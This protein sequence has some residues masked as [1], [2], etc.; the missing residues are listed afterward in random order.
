MKYFSIQILRAVS[1]LACLLA[2]SSCMEDFKKEAPGQAE[3]GIFAGGSQTRT[4]MLPNGLS[5]E[6]VP[7][8]QLALW[9]LNS[10]GSYTLSNQ[11]FQTF[12]L[13]ASRGFFTST[14]ESAMPEDTYTYY[15]CYPVPA[16]V[17]GMQ[18]TFS[19]P[20]LQDGKASGGVDVMMATPVNYGP[21]TAVPDPD[22]H[23]SMKM[24][25]NRMMHQFRF[26]VPEDDQL[27]GDEKLKSIHMSF[28]TE[29]TGNVTFDMNDLQAA[30]KIAD[31][32]TDVTLNL[33]Q[34]IGV[35]KGDNYEYAC[36]AF[37]PVQFA[38]GQALVVTKAYTDDKIALFDPVDLKAKQCLSGHSTPVQLRLRELI[39]YPFKIVFTVSSNNLGEGIN[40]VRFVAPE[41][42]DWNGTGSNVFEYTPGHKIEAGE[43]I[44]FYFDYHQENLYRAFN[45]QNISVTYDSDH[46]VLYETVNVGDVAG[47][48]AVAVSL[49]VPYLFYEDFSGLAAYDGGYKNGP[50]TSTDGA[51]EAGIDLTQYGIAGWSGAR[52]GCDAAGVAI[53]VSGRVDYVILG[54][55]RAYARL[56]SPTMSSLKPDANVSLELSFNY[57]GSKDGNSR[58][59]HA[60][61]V[62]TT[63][64]QGV[65]NGYATQFSN[66]KSWVGVTAPVEVTDIPT[67]GSAAAAN[68]SFTS[69]YED[70]TSATRLT[71]HVVAMGS[72]GIS[73]ANT[74]LYVDNVRVKIAN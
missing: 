60:A 12:G 33:V 25:M 27:L 36:F 5:A 74:W 31:G 14:L 24:E 17:D 39:D 20:S 55:T 44:A 48:D 59:S 29:V 8:D 6:W 62:G 45:G 61:V 53:A 56:D 46:A 51:T 3:V 35:S 9:A 73:N 41:G 58:F 10:S 13:D 22:D 28:P 70:C 47:S 64:D 57:S 50:Y 63:I 18:V 69:K 52:T 71:W 2:I 19:I 54:G 42:C 72:G 7:G 16:S 30:P 1:L 11:V 21:L 66:D 37:A 38:Q 49:T 26:Y 68:L 4:S 34:P 67:N 65:L 40:T 15:C 32:Q 43:Q 23:S